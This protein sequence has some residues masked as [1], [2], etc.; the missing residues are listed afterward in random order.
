MHYVS[1]VAM[2][3]LALIL[4]ANC[5]PLNNL[6]RQRREVFVDANGFFLGGGANNNLREASQLFDL[7]GPIVNPWL[8]PWTQPL[9][10]GGFITAPVAVS[11][12]V[13]DSNPVPAPAAEQTFTPAQ[14][15]SYGQQQVVAPQQQQSYGQ[16]QVLPPQQ[17]QSYGQQQ[18]VAPQ[19]QQ[20][21]YGPQQVLPPQQQQSYGQQQVLAPQQQQSY[22]QQQVVAPQQQQQSY[23]QQQVFAPQQQQP[24][25]Y[26]APQ[27]TLIQP[28]QSQ[29]FLATQQQGYGAPQQTFIPATAYN[30]PM[31]QNYNAPQ[32]QQPP[33]Q[34]YNAPP[35]QQ[36][37]QQSYSAPQQAPQQGYGSVQSQGVA[38]APGSPPDAN[39][40]PFT[41]VFIPGEQTKFKLGLP[42]DYSAGTYTSI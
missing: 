31:M 9:P 16:Q 26:G 6:N 11:G 29:G 20:Q 23:G 15:Q 2:L 25:Q 35:A 14:E 39:Q 21:S 1:F 27:A 36:L 22:G 7:G 8:N 24:Q 5:V 17:Q 42:Q 34:T 10:R 32:Q 12:G 30:S 3:A 4:P 18:F 37:P 40:K 33:K 19:Q 38:A 41:A 13:P 28:I